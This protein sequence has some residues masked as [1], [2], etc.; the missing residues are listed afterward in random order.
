VRNDFDLE[1]IH[2]NDQRRKLV[3]GGFNRFGEVV[4]RAFAYSVDSVAGPDFGEQPV[5]PG[6]PGD[7]GFDLADAHVH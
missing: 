2:A 7:E 6:I 3:D 4:E 1:W 5:L